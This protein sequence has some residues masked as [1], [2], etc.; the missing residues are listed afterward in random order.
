MTRR[1]RSILGLALLIAIPFAGALAGCATAPA[2]PG[3]RADDGNTQIELDAAWLDGGRMIGL[4]T[5][6][7][8]SCVPH[9]DTATLNAGVLEVALVEPPSDTPCTRDYVPR[10][11]LVGVPDGVDPTRDLEIAVTGD[12]YRGQTDLDGVPGLAGGGA[13]DYLPSAAW[14]SQDGQFILVTWGSSS[15][16]P[17]IQDA[18]A[19]GPAEITVTFV[20]PPADQICTADI[21]PR[22][23]VTTVPGFDD[24]SSVE[25]VLNGDSFDGTRVP[26]LARS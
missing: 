13:T 21:G 15:C 23:V 16:K 6:G 17:V 26:V 5:Q 9:V 19:S 11:T 14:T 3:P 2:G 20:E 25:L 18:E 12:G 7:S 4:V 8:S 10:V 1:H 24:S 22:A